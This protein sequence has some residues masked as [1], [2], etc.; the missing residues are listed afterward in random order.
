MIRERLRECELHVYGTHGDSGINEKL[1]LSWGQGT[2]MTK[3]QLRKMGVQFK[4]VMKE[5]EQLSEYRA[6]LYP[7]IHSTGP[8]IKVI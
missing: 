4:G 8:H 6:L 1:F 7:A 5:P 2:T 3:E